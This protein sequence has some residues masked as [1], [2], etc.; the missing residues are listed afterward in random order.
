MAKNGRKN[1]SSFIFIIITL[2]ELILF[3]ISGSI[4]LINTIKNLNIEN[5][6]LVIK[7]NE[8]KAIYDTL[9]SN[10]DILNIELDKYVNIDKTISSE[11]EEVFKLAST[12]EKNIMD[13]KSKAKIAYLTFD[14][15]PYYSTHKYLDI[16][17]KYNVKATFF[18]IGLDKEKCYDNR[19][20]SCTS[21]YKKIVD[22]GHTIANHTYSHLIHKGLYSNATS[23]MNQV[24][25]Q[26]DLIKKK[27]GVITNIVRF[28]GGSG[29]AQSYGIKNSAIK[30]LKE[31]NY[32]WVDWTAM[33][34]DGG[35]L[36]SKEQAL[37]TFKKSIN[38][39][40]EVV[41]LHDYSTITKAILPDIITYLEK[42]NYILLPLFYDSVK[43]NK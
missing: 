32:G 15:G 2:G 16:L 12:L 22:N 6:K 5:E 20:K 43:I 1:K 3:S 40:I 8:N 41:L 38:E 31:N 21:I 19:S 24:K 34:G 18:T 10:N 11:K 28:P 39:N 14:D 42:N 30:K 33:D 29:T 37:S 27:T 7:I 17:K 36:Y 35:A 13:K 25:K 26:E 23:F 4:L 9:K